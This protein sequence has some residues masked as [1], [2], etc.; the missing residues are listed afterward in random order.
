MAVSSTFSIIG[1]LSTI[2]IARMNLK[3]LVPQNVLFIIN[4]LLLINAL[5]WLTF[6]ESKNTL[7]YFNT[8][9]NVLN[10]AYSSYVFYSCSKVFSTSNP[11]LIGI[12]IAAFKTSGVLSP[13]IMAL[14]V[15]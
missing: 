2:M 4:I 14:K 13:I 12:V 6:I 3:M 7:I 1:S 15:D 10:L 5:T 9:T 8:L 11:L